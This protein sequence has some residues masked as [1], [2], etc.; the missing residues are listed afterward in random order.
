MEEIKEKIIT[1]LQQKKYDEL[2]IKELEMIS[3]IYLKL[4]EKT[5]QE[6]F[7]NR[8]KGGK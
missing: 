7:S 4:K 3:N 5:V 8:I 2:N 6:Q 1:S